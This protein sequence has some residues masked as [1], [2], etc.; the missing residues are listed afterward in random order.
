MWIVSVI[1]SFCLGVL[2]G[3]QLPIWLDAWRTYRCRKAFRLN[4]LEQYTPAAEQQRRSD[5]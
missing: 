3:Y 4:L 2:A 5:S 1:F